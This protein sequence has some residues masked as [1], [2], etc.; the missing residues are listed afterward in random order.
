[1]LLLYY[2]WMLNASA[3]QGYTIRDLE[4]EKNKLL[5]EKAKLDVQ[6]AELDS[7]SNIMNSTDLQNMEKIENPNYLV[8]K[9]NV[10][11]TYNY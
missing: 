11:Y 4:V 7:L 3:T 5:M 2:V 1:M 10:Q 6:I 8:I 9:D